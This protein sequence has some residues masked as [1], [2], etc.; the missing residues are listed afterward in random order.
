VYGA[1][2]RVGIGFIGCG[3]R[4][5]ELLDVFLP[6]EEDCQ[7]VA[8]CDVH[9]PYLNFAKGKAG[10]LIHSSKDYRSM[11]EQKA[12]DAVVIAT[13]DHW[14]ALQMIEACQ[15][16]K[17]VYV[18]KPLSLTVAE[19]RAMAEAA[20]K[21]KRVV[22]VGLQRRSSNLCK[23]AV[24]LVRRGSLGQIVL[25]RAFHIQ[26][27]WPNGIGTPT[28]GPPPERL[29]WDKW[30]GPAPMKPYNPSRAFC[31]FRWFYDYS[32]GQLTNNGVQHLDLLHWLMSQDAPTTVA[33]LGGK[34]FIKDNREVPDTLEVIW[35]YP[36]NVTVTFTQLNANGAS[37][38]S[39]PNTEVEIRGTKG[40]L[41]LQGRNY[42]FIPETNMDLPYP[43]LSPL[44]RGAMK[45]YRESAKVPTSGV[46][47][48]P[49]Q[50]ETHAHVRNFL[51]CVKSRSEP[52]STIESAHR[53]TTAANIANI[54]LKKRA[55]LD[56]DGKTEQF[57]NNKE[58]NSLLR[59]EYRAPYKLP[60]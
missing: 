10:G 58:A 8:F 16:N 9:E 12:V 22:Q 36:N 38:S 30:V 55:I 24:E 49:G 40:T 20:K 37:A 21:H 11:L 33:A 15:A 32:G 57:T 44:D 54:A 31:H 7:A 46:R 23:D 26:N 56:W 45:R 27:E 19:G 52:N 51:E 34:Y 13:P 29:D 60:G 41:Y 2:G 18:E 3:N 42:T 4:G 47:K 28:D 43:V 48:G 35:Q 50:S 1:N 59:Y 53:A 17:D 39:Q 14:H 25:C 5:D 6:L